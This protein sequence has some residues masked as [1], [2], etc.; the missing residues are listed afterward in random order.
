[1]STQ[2]DSGATA[3]AALLSDDTSMWQLLLLHSVC[4]LQAADSSTY[5][6]MHMYV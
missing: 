5:A 4:I 3:A 2:K 1:M 6:N